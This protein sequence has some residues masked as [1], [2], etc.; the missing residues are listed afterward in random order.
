MVKVSDLKEFDPADFLETP[1][2]RARFV[3]A[4]FEDGDPVIIRKALGAVARSMGMKDVAEAANLNRESLYRSLGENGNPELATILKLMK[5]MGLT[6]A[7]NPTDQTLAK[8]G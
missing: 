4:A 7:A 1:E 2:D 3:S 6:L 5:A 8:T